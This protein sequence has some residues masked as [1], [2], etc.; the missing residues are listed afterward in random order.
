MTVQE[1][2]DREG[3]SKQAVYSKISRGIIPKDTGQ[4]GLRVKEVNK[5]QFMIEEN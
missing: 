2:A 5:T 4:K 3:I 1:Y